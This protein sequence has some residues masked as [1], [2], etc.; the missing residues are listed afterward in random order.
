[1]VTMRAHSEAFSPPGTFGAAL[2]CAAVLAVSP[3]RAQPP[4]FNQVHTIAAATTGVP[5]EEPFTISTA[6]TYTLT[7]TDLGAELSPSAPLASVALAVTNSQDQIVGTPLQAAGTLTLSAIPAGN[8][9]LH[10]VGMPGN[11]PGS[12]P[13]GIVVNSSSMTQVAAFQEVIALP[14]QSLPNGEAVLNDSF[15]VQ[16][17]GNYTVSLND[18]QLP[19]SLGTLTLL[20]IAQGSA[21]PVV[22]LP[23]AGVYQAT[24]ALTA[25]VTYQIFAVGEAGNAANA[26]L[27][28]AVVTASGGGVVYGRAVPVGNTVHLGS[29]ALAAGNTTLT[30]ADLSFP[31]SLSQVAAA[32]LLNGQ[33]VAQ[34]A[35]AGNQPFMASATTYE[36][37]AVGIAGAA[38][39]EAGS[40]V[41]EVT[42]QGSTPIF[43]AAQGVTASG[44]GLTA[45]DFQTTLAAGGAETVTLT[46]FE[47][48]AILSS[49]SLAAV[50]GTAVLGAP[51]NRA[52]TLNITPA[53]GP[54]SFVVF[55]QATAS[56]GLFG[57]HVAPSGGAA[58]YDVTQAVGAVFSSEQVPIPDAGAYAVTATDLGFPAKFANFDVIVTQ[59]TAQVGSIIGGGTFNFAATP[60]VY[61]VNFIAQ[62]AAPAEAGTYALSVA[63]APATPTVS[64]STDNSQ[65]SSGST[66]D[67][68]W[69]SENAASCTASG[70]WSGS[71]AL[72]GTETS[73]AL[74][75]T[76]TFT[77]TCSGAGGQ[78]SKSVTVTVTGSSGG[79]GALDELLLAVLGV[80]L[81]SRS[82]QHLIPSR[83]R[84]VDG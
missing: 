36:A 19:E 45:Y 72:S 79:G 17:S 84:G 81:L 27:Y 55:A 32:L 71:K 28:S 1:M 62:P 47:F 18:L 26:G 35:A 64:L 2:V 67:L 12:G 37:Y 65:V 51:I 82:L 6:G 23:N 60:G 68:V 13:I 34:L 8:Y 41:L 11:V 5:V 31:A 75:S 33:S 15:S 14:S 76:T 24:V 50:Q 7:L 10:V 52:T 44:S 22:T 40:Y 63:S 66:V 77:L 21:T 20:V 48:P 42:P 16:T 25:G 74:T 56:G 30:L 69:S 80:L 53:A 83:A 29:P 9:E 58:V 70:G 73:A 39:P 78:A 54:L 38:A 49:V 46:D 3:V 57:I 43:A 61:F 59:G 4:L